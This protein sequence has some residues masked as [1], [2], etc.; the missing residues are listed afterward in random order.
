MSFLL[1]CW[2]IFVVISLLAASIAVYVPRFGDRLASVCML[3]AKM[4]SIPEQPLVKFAVEILKMRG[5]VA[6]V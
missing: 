2:S 3:P 4:N 1:L 5:Q 6:T